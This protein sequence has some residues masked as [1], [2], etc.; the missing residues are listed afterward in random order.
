MD[1]NRTSY[2]NKEEFNELYKKVTE[3]VKV[4]TILELKMLLGPLL[5]SKPLNVSMN[6]KVEWTDGDGK[7]LISSVSAPCADGSLR[8]TLLEGMQKVKDRIESNTKIHAAI[9]E[10]KKNDE[11]DDVNMKIWDISNTRFNVDSL[12][13]KRLGGKRY[14]VRIRWE[15]VEGTYE[16]DPFTNKLYEVTKDAEL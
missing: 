1:R 12:I 13:E 3:P 8:E 7:K 14:G 10:A 16:F 5:K 2:K 11:I 15:L 4:N 9:N 6:T